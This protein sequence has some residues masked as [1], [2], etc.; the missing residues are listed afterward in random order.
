MLE[1]EPGG[2]WVDGE[3][4]QR[5]HHVVDGAGETLATFRNE[6]D[7]KK[8]IDEQ[9]A[10]PEPDEEA[11]REAWAEQAAEAAAERRRGW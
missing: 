10:E 4:V 8:W 3:G 2:V 7:A 11:V 5:F 1:I 6:E 9:Q